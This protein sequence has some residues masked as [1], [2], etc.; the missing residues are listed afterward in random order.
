MKAVI[1]PKGAILSTTV[2]VKIHEDR[3]V[4]LT[5]EYVFER[6]KETLEDNDSTS[7]TVR[8]NFVSEIL[9]HDD[10]IRE[11]DNLKIHLA[12]LTEAV[13][14]KDYSKKDMEGMIATK[15]GEAIFPKAL[16][17]LLDKF[18]LRS[19]SISGND[20]KGN[21][22]IVLSGVRKLRHRTKTIAVNTPLIFFKDETHEY[23]FMDN[24]LFTLDRI[25][26]EVE[27][28]MRGKCCWDANGQQPLFRE[29]ETRPIIHIEEGA[30]DGT[31]N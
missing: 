29:E 7:A 12:M 23:K 31:N 30:K 21:K 20:F 3:K 26:E 4:D 24:L 11:M 19:F 25:E 22:G 1:V 27:E 5:R 2:K 9:A 18:E 10:F 6:P 8:S 14:E 28:Y 17:E 13:N 15:E 16:K